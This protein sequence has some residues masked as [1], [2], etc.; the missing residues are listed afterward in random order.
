MSETPSE[1]R[2]PFEVEWR[3]LRSL[4][5]DSLRREPETIRRQQALAVEA[6]GEL[7]RILCLVL[8]GELVLGREAGPREV[9]RLELSRD[10]FARLAERDLRLLALLEEPAARQAERSDAEADPPGC[11]EEPSESR[12][13]REPVLSPPPAL[14]PSA[15]VDA[16][17]G[18]LDGLQD[19]ETLERLRA[20]AEALSEQELTDFLERAAWR[21]APEAWEATRPS[22]RAE[23]LRRN[24]AR[25][26]ELSRGGETYA[27]DRRTVGP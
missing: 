26:R 17:M 1:L 21:V 27:G 14:A 11:S 5:Q 16:V 7:E 10:T 24:I 18:E 13:I 6:A 2:T 22:D 23:W 8:E 9:R 15:L 20:Q 4:G 3:W 12:S 19:G 25:W